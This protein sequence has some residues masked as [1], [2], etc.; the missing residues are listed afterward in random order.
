MPSS[1]IALQEIERTQKLIDKAQ[2][3]AA[4]PDLASAAGR[5]E[6]IGGKT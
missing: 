4:S 6:R 1:G 2:Q 5:A 3:P